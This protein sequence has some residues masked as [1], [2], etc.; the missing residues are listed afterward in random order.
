MAP[1][2]SP[3]RVLRLHL[4]RAVVVA[5]VASPL[6]HAFAD[7]PTAL[8]PA[9]FVERVRG[10][11][12]RLDGLEARIDAARAELTAARVLPN[13]VISYDREEVFAGGD[14]FPENY[15]TL[16]VPVDVSGRRSLRIEAAETGVAAARA[17][18]ERDR[19]L[20]LLDALDLY[21][22]AAYLRRR[23]DALA[24][25]RAAL[26]R[27]VD[28]VRKRVREGESSELDLQR[29][30]MDLT[31]HD[32]ALA[33]AAIALRSSR[34]AL[35]QLV[36][37][38]AVL[39]EAADHLDPPA[40]MEAVDELVR[41][42]IESR[43]DARAA[44]LRTEQAAKDLAAA[45]R[46]WIPSFV[47]SGGY[48]ESDLGEGTGTGRGYVAGIAME[49]PLFD[50]GQA[51]Q[52]RAAAAKVEAESEARFLARRVSAEVRRA[53]DALEMR[54]AQALEYQEKQVAQVPDMLRRTEALYREGEQP[55]LA[56]VDA[57][58]TAR[59]A[60]LRDLELRRAVKRSEI[61]LWRALGREP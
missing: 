23:R 32:D 16:S 58:R 2:E 24:Q 12:P 13:P 31:A 22:D 8:A 41:F 26:A 61:E 25:Q 40:S 54:V 28:V 7:A 19:G 60:V 45:R 59:E 15:L 6:G 11:D 10:T 43:G 55:V 38:P 18:A 14:S 46:W 20:L 48:K 9:E 35:A 52:A 21:Y 44:Q 1:V 57:Y 39:L 3:R 56:L 36:G 29:L 37:D 53:R 47:L 27:V 33:D 30:E 34:L 5:V 17:T 4:L 51:A 42:A 50:R 49:V